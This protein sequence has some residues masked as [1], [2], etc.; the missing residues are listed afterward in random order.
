MNQM[1]NDDDGIIMCIHSKLVINGVYI[2]YN[3]YNIM[4][5][6]YR[7]QGICFFKYIVFIAY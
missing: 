6:K 4:K 5:Y 2:Q 7:Q 1:I 3:V